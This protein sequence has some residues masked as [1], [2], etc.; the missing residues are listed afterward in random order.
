MRNTPWRSIVNVMNRVQ[1]EILLL[2]HTGKIAT[3][4]ERTRY[5]GGRANG[6]MLREGMSLNELRRTISSCL[7]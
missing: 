5:V 3:D 4:Q 7:G 1:K 2:P 6:R